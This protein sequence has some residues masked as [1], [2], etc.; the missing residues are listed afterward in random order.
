M[1]CQGNQHPGVS[2]THGSHCSTGNRRHKPADSGPPAAPPP[3]CI[4]LQEIRPQ[5]S[6]CP[7]AWFHHA[8]SSCWV[9]QNQQASLRVLSACRLV[10]PMPAVAAMAPGSP[11]SNASRSRDLRSLVS[12]RRF[13]LTGFVTQCQKAATTHLSEPQAPGFASL[14]VPGDFPPH[15]AQRPSTPHCP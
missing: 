14:L 3:N 7:Q 9:P 12:T 11:H 15:G 13:K 2:R 4:S 6:R 8:C 10:S 1:K 5:T